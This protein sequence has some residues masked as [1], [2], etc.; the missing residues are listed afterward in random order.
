VV[1]QGNI[2]LDKKAAFALPVVFAYLTTLHV[3]YLLKKEYDTF[4]EYRLDYLDHGDPD[5]NPQKV[6]VFLMHRSFIPHQ[7]S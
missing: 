7:V 2:K 5:V 4:V 6:I 1:W 3:L